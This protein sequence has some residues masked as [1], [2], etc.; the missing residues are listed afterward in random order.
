[1]PMG[2][3]PVLE[4]NGKRAHQSIAIA[5]YLAKQV[6][7]AGNDDWESLTIDTA[8]DCINDFRLKIAVVSYE[9]DEAVQAKKRVTLNSET[10]PYYLGKLDAMVAENNGYFALG[11][12][13]WADLYFAAVLDYL[14]YMTKTDLISNHANLKKNVA[15]VLALDGIKQWVEKRPKSDL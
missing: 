2:Q 4:F 10:I 6:G 14:N 5:R 13:T 12:L 7:L 9:A 3:M 8:V 15:N 11:R 1:M